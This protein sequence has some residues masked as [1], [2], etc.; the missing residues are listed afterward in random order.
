MFGGSKFI[1]PTVRERRKKL[2]IRRFLIGLVLLII[3][4]LALAFIPRIDAFSIN[5]IA[6]TGNSIEASDELSTYIERE[7]SG[8]YFYLIPKN[9]IFFYPK[10]SIERKILGDFTRINKVELSY[11]GNNSLLLDVVERKPYWLWCAETCFFMDENL[12]IFAKAPNFSGNVFF[13]AS[14]GLEADEPIGQFYKLPWE[15][16]EFILFIEKLKELNLKAVGVF[17]TAEE[18]IEVKLEDNTILK[19]NPE[20]KLATTYA[21][22]ETVLNSNTAGAKLPLEYIDLRFPNKVFYQ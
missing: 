17:I 5:H 14:G 12:F 6:V 3:I 2:L 16:N 20:K 7:I 21:D 19:I 9:N 8:N 13:K 22:L 15:R 18:D 4:A 11:E 1:S 10:R